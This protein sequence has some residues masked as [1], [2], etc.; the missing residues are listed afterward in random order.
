MA[1]FI[2]LALLLPLIAACSTVGGETPADESVAL[3]TVT[4]TVTYRERIALT[5]EAMV[6]VQL[7]DVSIADASAKLIAEQTIKPQ[8]QVPI[9]FDRKTLCVGAI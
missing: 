3:G 8:H 7:L 1:R 5:P 6:E 2:K 4:G 9:P